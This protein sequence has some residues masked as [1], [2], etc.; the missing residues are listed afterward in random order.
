LLLKRKSAFKAPPR[1]GINFR[2]E[3]AL[4]KSTTSDL[5]L[6]DSEALKPVPGECL[7]KNGRL[8]EDLLHYVAQ[9]GIDTLALLDEYKGTN[10]SLLRKR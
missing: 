7:V 4:N 8:I 2:I 1:E 9:T 6:R 10:W 3:K 5:D